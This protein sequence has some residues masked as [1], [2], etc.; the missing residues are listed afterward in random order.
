MQIKTTLKFH[1]TVSRM[2][3]INKNN[4]SSY[5]QRVRGTC[6]CCWWEYKLV[7]PLWKSVWQL[8]RKM[9]INL[10]Q[11]SAVSLLGIYYQDASSY[12][13]DTCSTIFIIA[14][15]WKQ[16]RCLSV[17]ERIKIMWYV[18]RLKYYSSLK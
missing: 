18:Y 4:D 2:S 8:L 11:D 13:R 6:V 1:L 7:Q 9:G 5:C 3:K 15:N 12:Y 17:G 16:H 14:R 10:S